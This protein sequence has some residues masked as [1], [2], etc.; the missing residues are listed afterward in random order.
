M[1]ELSSRPLVIGVWASLVFFGGYFAVA[2]LVGWHNPAPWESAIGE[3]SRWC[4][5]VAP[6]AFRE[7][8]NALSNIGFML[9][10]LWMLWVLGRDERAGLPRVGL[11]GFTSSSLVY[12]GA[13]WFLGPGSLM[14][15]GTHAAWGGWLDNLSM[16]MYILIPWMLN[17]SQMG[18]WSMPQFLWTYA[19]VVAVYALLRAI[20]WGLYG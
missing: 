18:R 15:H 9:G 10:G 17:L 7:P 1:R 6:G 13:A 2:H 4:E 14:M 8:V 12:A 11:Q 20:G 19:A 16:V 3:A 5:R